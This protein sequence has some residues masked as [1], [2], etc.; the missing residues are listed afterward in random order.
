M[1]IEKPGRQVSLSAK[2][3]QNLPMSQYDNSFTFIVGGNRYSC[4][5]VFAHFLSPRLCHLHTGDSTIRELEIETEDPHGYF[6]KVL[7]LGRGET[8]ELVEDQK[9]FIQS[10]GAEFSNPEL[11]FLSFLTISDDLSVETICSRLHSLSESGSTHTAES[12]FAASHFYEFSVS[13]CRSLGF[14]VLYS[15]LSSPNLI[16]HSEDSLFETIREISKDE[17]YFSLLEFVRFEFLSEG[18]MQSAIECISHSFELLTFPIWESLSK[19]LVISDRPRPSGNRF[20][21]RLAAVGS[22]PKLDSQI[23]SEFP[24]IFVRF[25]THVFRLLYRGSRDGF[26]TASF[27]HLCDGHSMTLTVILSDNGSIFGGYT[28]VA[29]HSS[30][31]YSIDNT[32]KSFLFTLK[33]QHNIGARIFPLNEDRKAYAIYGHGSYGAS[34]GSGH[35]LCVYNQCNINSSS[36]TTGFGQ[37]YMNDTGLPGDTVFTGGSNFRVREIEVF[38]LTT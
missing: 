14:P 29:W 15:I 10:I 37:T 38:E 4:P 17:S 36:Y 19:R 18:W 24:D 2:G 9:S 30:S 20:L 25:R 34:F 26:E 8:I 28:P 21:A 1:S 12:E 23:I 13:D 27:H 7:S 33:N 22:A 6:S 35:N 32:L 3:L 5:L 16:L 31:A 11:S